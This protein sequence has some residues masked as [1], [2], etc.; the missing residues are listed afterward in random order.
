MSKLNSYGVRG[1]CYNLLRS[2]LSNRKQF[3][4][5]NGFKSS[6]R[7][8]KCGVPQGSVLGP[9]LF[10]IYI[11]DLPSVVNKST[12][13][14]FADDTSIIK[15]SNS[16]LVDFQNDLNCVDKWMRSN[17]LTVEPSKS[18]LIVFN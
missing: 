17:K 10:L 6:Q 2:Y 16:S 5:I 1:I 9:L 12:I 14:L 4:E 3:V 15:N 11:N 8:V 7:T 18:K 13:I